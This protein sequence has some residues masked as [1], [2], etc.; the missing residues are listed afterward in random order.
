MA[1]A[2]I[3]LNYFKEFLS[4][5]FFHLFLAMEYFLLSVQATKLQLICNPS[6]K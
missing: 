1:L 3:C 5:A 6:L 4:V 2:I